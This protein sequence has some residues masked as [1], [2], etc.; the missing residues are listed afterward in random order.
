MKDELKYK[1]F[2]GSVHWSPM[3]GVFFGKIEGIQDLVT[4]EGTTVEELEIGFQ[5][6]VDEL[7]LERGE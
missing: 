2:N 5:S 3:D 1:G 7:I 4:F 6:M